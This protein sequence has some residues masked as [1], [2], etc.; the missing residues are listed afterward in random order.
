MLKQGLELKQKQQLSPLQIQTIKLIEL[1]IQDPDIL[2]EDG[3]FN[4]NS[5]EDAIP[6]R[7]ML[8][9]RADADG[10]IPVIDEQGEQEKIRLFKL[11]LARINTLRAEQGLPEL[12]AEEFL[13][14]CRPKEI[15]DESVCT[16]VR[17]GQ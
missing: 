3:N 11:R 6:D 8:K 5:L 12:T 1:P 17:N 7:D 10:N 13:A 15:T 2:D 4:G 16:L 9:E 14:R